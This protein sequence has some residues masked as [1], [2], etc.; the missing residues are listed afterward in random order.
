MMIIWSRFWSN[1]EKSNSCWFWK[2]NI[3]GRCGYGMFK[4]KGRKMQAHRVSYELCVG[5]IPK[6]LI[7]DHLCRNVTCVNPSHLEPVSNRENILRGIGPSA[8]NS[9]KTNCQ[10]GHPFSI[11]NTAIV[12]GKRCCRICRDISRREFINAHKKICKCGKEMK[13]SAKVC[14]RCYY[15]RGRLPESLQ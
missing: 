11:E 14:L 2:S 5:A 7:L 1:V 3:Q 15:E 4:V 10:R 9:R 12:Q 8:I 6:G 13:Y